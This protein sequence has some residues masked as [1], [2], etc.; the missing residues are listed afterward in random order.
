MGEQ[1][2]EFSKEFKREARLMRLGCRQARAW[3]W[4]RRMCRQT[5]SRHRREDRK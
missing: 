3:Y 2:R 5:R 4:T 1:R